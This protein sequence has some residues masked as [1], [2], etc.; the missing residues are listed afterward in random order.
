MMKH[1]KAIQ[2]V[3]IIGSINSASEEVFI[4]QAGEKLIKEIPQK[5]HPKRPLEN[6]K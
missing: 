6:K 3:P 2:K 4:T 5:A 1:R